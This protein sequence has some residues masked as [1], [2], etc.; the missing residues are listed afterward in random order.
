VRVLFDQGVPAP[1]RDHLH[2]HEVSTAFELGWSELSNGE[3]L[4]MA[5]PRFHVL[6]TTD[7]NLPSQQNLTGRRIAILVLPTT[8]WPLLQSIAPRIAEELNSIAPGRYR[9]IPL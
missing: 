9:E 6:I 8:S 3:L 5:E 7:R 1:L 4:A 2:G